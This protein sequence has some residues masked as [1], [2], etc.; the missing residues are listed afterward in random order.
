MILRILVFGCAMDFRRF[1]LLILGL[2]CTQLIFAASLTDGPYVFMR[3]GQREAH[4]ICEGKLQTRQIAVHGKI[5]PVCGLVPALQLESQR[6][7]AADE[8][9]QV[10]RWAAVS[11]V[12]GQNALLLSLL[13]AQHIVDEQGNWAWRRGVLIVVGDVFDRGPNQLEA[14]WAIY[15]W[16]QQAR[17][18]GGRVELLLGN[19]EIMVLTGDLRYLHE[20][21]QAVAQLLGRSYD[22]LF[23]ESTE[24]GAWLRARATVLKLGDTL[25]THGGLHPVFADQPIDLA[26]INAAFRNYLSQPS[27]QRDPQTAWLVGNDGPTWYRGYFAPP[28]ASSTQVQALLKQAKVERIVVGHT[29][30]EQIRSFY[31]GGVIAIDAGLKNGER[32]ELLVFEKGRLWRGLLDGQRVP[33]ALG[34]D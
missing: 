14:L 16:A 28:R 30:Q 21:Y 13:R 6:T 33:L 26:S 2:C 23:A 32:G 22:Q 5:K 9:P 34:Y 8:L 31:Q 24:L 1:V 15:R 19:H 27:L 4:W 29:T 20:K 10:R 18:A 7:Q 3:D 11:D 25:F 17:A 12:H